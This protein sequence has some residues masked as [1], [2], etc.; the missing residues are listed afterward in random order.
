MRFKRFQA[1]QEKFQAAHDKLN[2]A[3]TQ[4]ERDAILDEM[5]LLLN[6]YKGV[7]NEEDRRVQPPK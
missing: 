3:E 7:S 6:K 4:A 5:T 1:L 2:R